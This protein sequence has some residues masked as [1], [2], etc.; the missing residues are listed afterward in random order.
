MALLENNISPSASRYPRRYP[1][2]RYHAHILPF[3][4]ITGIAISG[5]VTHLRFVEELDRDADRGGELAHFDCVTAS[6]DGKRLKKSNR[7]TDSFPCTKEETNQGNGWSRGDGG[8]VM[9]SE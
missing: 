5:N 9:R 2:L 3:R 8:T 7:T 6:E 4:P 1:F